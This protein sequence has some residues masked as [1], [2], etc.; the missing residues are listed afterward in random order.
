MFEL[1]SLRRFARDRCGSVSVVGALMLP[2]L[3]GM[4]A[5][6]IEYSG[7][8]LAKVE[9]QR[10]ADLS[11]N[12]GASAYASHQNVSKM[13][14]A[15]QGIAIL[16]GI[17]REN[18]NV[19]LEPSPI[20]PGAKAVRVTIT[21]QRT[22]LLARV[23][24]SREFLD[25]EVDAL[26]AAV[27][28]D[29]A[30][31]QALDPSGSGVTLSGGTSVTADECVIASNARVIAPCGTHITATAVNY[32]SNAAPSQCNNISTASGGATPLNNMQTPDPLVGNAAIGLATARIATVAAMT[33][34]ATPTGGDINF[35]WNQSATR[36]QATAI[37]CVGSFASSTWTL[38]CPGRTTVNLGNITI[39]GGL[40]LNFGTGGAA[41]TVYNFSGGIQNGGGSVMLFASGIYNIAKGITVPGGSRVEFAA[42][43]FRVGPANNGNAIDLGGGATL[44]MGSTLATGGIFQI[45]GNVRTDG[46]SCLV[47]GAAANHDIRGYISA[48]GAVV[49]GAGVYTLDGYLHLGANYGGSSSCNGATVSLRAIDVTIILSGKNAPTGGWAC[50]DKAFCAA[51]GYSNMILRAPETGPFTKLALIGPTNAS[52]RSGA[53][54]TSGASGGQISG[55]FYFPNGPISLSGGA[56]GSGSNSG[57][58]QIIGS[59]VTLSGG[60]TLASECIAPVGGSQ[61]AVRLLE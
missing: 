45:V 58:L 40:T 61:T 60:S 23:L 37:G 46:G 13:T 42:G 43:A 28:G 16:N 49:L 24:S 6:A 26:A 12:A 53:A 34:P 17:A 27:A 47:F 35:G 1:R 32:G 30:C 25:V 18:V 8:V 55:A 3:L 57:C 22:L 5:L 36:N 7:A 54:L 11:A 2:I 56:T 19:A 31:I 4:S 15:A 29:S 9:T 39:G 59:T 48:S 10:V 38:T 44:V 50:P 14:L 41:T 33:A 51:A 21:T 20:M 52:V